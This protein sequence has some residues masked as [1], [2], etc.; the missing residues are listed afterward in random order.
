MLVLLKKF[1]EICMENKIKYSL[2]GGTLLGA[3]REKGFIPWDNDVDIAMTRDEY[4]KFR[5]L[6]TLKQEEGFHFIDWIDHYPRFCLFC[7][8]KPTVWLDILIFDYITSNKIGQKLKIGG[9]LFLD[10]FS[11][12]K[13]S[14]ETTRASKRYPGWHYAVFYMVYLLGRLFPAE[15]KIH[16]VHWFGKHAFLGGKKLMHMSNDQY[17]GIKLVIP[18]ELLTDYN[19]LLFEGNKFMAFSTYKE[20]LIKY[21]GPDYMKPRKYNQT[22]AAHEVVRIILENI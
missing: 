10:A 6:C 15:W 13:E 2:H 20:L 12:T 21:Y 4:E 1:H 7:K 14:I 8:G 18:C 9:I 3:V 5:N 16:M 17:S 19:F 11:K 22:D